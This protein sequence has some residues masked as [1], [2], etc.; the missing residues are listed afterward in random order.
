METL[1]SIV[2]FD[3]A[4]ICKFLA[5]R[6]NS[7]EGFFKLLSRADFRVQTAIF[8]HLARVIPPKILAPFAP[9][10]PTPL[11]V[12]A[13]HLG[14]LDLTSSVLAIAQALSPPSLPACAYPRLTPSPLAHCPP[15]FVTSSPAVAPSRTSSVRA[16]GTE[17][18]LQH[19]LCAPWTTSRS[20]PSY[21]TPTRFWR[22]DNA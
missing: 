21:N 2:G 10:F 5:K 20:T 4:E 1:G 15:C 22:T 9:E 8:G 12:E 14:C 18:R 7:F 3:E 13:R 19:A 17:P 16:E 11:P 6:V